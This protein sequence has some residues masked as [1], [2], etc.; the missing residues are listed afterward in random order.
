[1]TIVIFFAEGFALASVLLFGPKM[2]IGIFMGQFLLIYSSM[3]LISGLSIA[4]VNSLEALLAVTLFDYFKLDRKL[5]TTQDVFGLIALIIFVLQPFSAL[6]GNSILLS[7]SM[8]EMADFGKNFF[9]WWLGNVVGQILIVPTLL[10]LYSRNKETKVIKLL[11]LG[12]FFALISYLF[13]VLV[14]IQ[15]ISLLLSVTLPLIIY[16]SSRNGIQY[17][18]FS[19]LVIT[20]VTLYLSYLGLGVFRTKD[21]IDDLINLNFYFLSQMLLILI[22]GTL[23]E[24]RKARERELQSLIEKEVKK[25]EEQSLMMLQQ[26]RLAQMGQV[27]NM[28]AHQWRQPLNNLLLIGEVLVY[29]YENNELDEEEVSRFQKDSSLLIKQMSRTIDDFRDFFEPRKKQER[30]LLNDVIEELLQLVAPI[31]TLENIDVSFKKKDQL[32][33]TG[34]PNEFSQAILNILYNAKDVFI[35]RSIKDKL[36]T[37]NLSME[38]DKILLSISDNAGGIPDE[39]ICDIFN[40]YFSTKKNLNGTGL[41]LY[42]SKMIIE[43]HMGGMLIAKNNEEGAVFIITLDQT[44]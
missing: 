39:I 14:P 32:Y 44:S 17:A 4:V 21:G 38:N 43:T 29:K 23:F 2:L 1:M 11:L 42:M 22:I 7:S 20:G 19:I 27:I 18:T 25:N 30:F 31:F 24:E 33:V 3:P 28:I 13:Q 35:S 9:S 6:L 36:V 26:S 15:N 10:L 41:G 34:Y 16:T 5:S 37:I 8:I 12:L 40:P